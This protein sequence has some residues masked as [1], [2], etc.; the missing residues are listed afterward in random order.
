MFECTVCRTSYSTKNILARHNRNHNPD[1]QHRCEVCSVVFRRSDLLQR[2]RKIHEPSNEAEEGSSIRGRQRCN[3]ACVRC[4]QLRCKC[5]GMLPCASC[6]KSGEA[7]RFEQGTHR[8][9]RGMLLNCSHG[10]DADVRPS[11][12]CQHTADIQPNNSGL[13]VADQKLDGGLLEAT[14]G[15]VD[16]K[17]TDLQDVSVASAPGMSL[18]DPHHMQ[19]INS[20]QNWQWAYD[21]S[22]LPPSTA[23]NLGTGHKS[24]GDVSTGKNAMSE[25]LDFTASQIPESN[26][27]ST[28]SA[29]ASVEDQHLGSAFATSFS[30]LLNDHHAYLQYS[31]ASYQPMDCFGMGTSSYPDLSERPH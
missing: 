18:T 5:D 29:F 8:Q 21:D 10:S 25:T 27:V 4:R 24:L 16:N 14:V 20:P 12:E 17:T 30:E 3:I 6:T 15:R 31:D 22:F 28:G 26:S 7:C 9:S 23:F 11:N 1:W 19:S 2:H 13:D